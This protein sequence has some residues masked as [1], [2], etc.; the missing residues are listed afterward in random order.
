ME[1]KIVKRATLKKLIL[2]MFN[3]ITGPIE[4]LIMTFLR[5]TWGLYLIKE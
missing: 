5:I 3:K 1:T 4:K 2:S